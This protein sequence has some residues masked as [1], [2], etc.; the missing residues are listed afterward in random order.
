MQ[1]SAQLPFK[2]TETCSTGKQRSRESKQPFYVDSMLGGGGVQK[3]YSIKV[4]STFCVKEH[5]FH[6]KP[7]WLRDPEAGT[8]CSL[9]Q[10]A[11]LGDYFVASYSSFK[12]KIPD[13]V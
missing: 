10:Y 9:Y 11:I 8:F 7:L 13:N 4:A 1:S 5:A 2:G 6:T 3:P 12:S